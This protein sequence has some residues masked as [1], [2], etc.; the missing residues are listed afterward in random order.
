M[1]I[2]AYFRVPDM[3]PAQYDR[4][5]DGL[6]AAGLG[7]PEGRRYHVAALA[8]EGMTVLDVWDAEELLNRFAER[9]MPLVASTGVNP[10]QPEVRPAHNFIAGSAS[11]PPAAEAISVLFRAPDMTAAQ[12]DQIVAGLEGLGL[13]APQ[14]RRCHASVATDD[15]WMLFGVWDSEEALRRFGERL[16]PLIAAA[17]VTL[18]PP[19]IR[20]VHN[21]V[22]GQPAAAFAS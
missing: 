21:V 3:S 6:E 14:G 15:G 5:I 9:L 20:P 8:D 7:A 19:E 12:Y 11:T 22:A 18:S 1:A 2:I 16:M 17:G 13:G 10:P 4:I